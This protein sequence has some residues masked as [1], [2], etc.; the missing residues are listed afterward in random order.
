MIL[1]VLLLFFIVIILFTAYKLI[2]NKENEKRE[3]E[4]SE[5]LEVSGNNVFKS[6]KDFTIEYKASKIPRNIEENNQYISV[7]YITENGNYIRMGNSEV[8]KKKNEVS[9]ET[10]IPGN[11]VVLCRKKPYGITVE[12]KIKSGEEPLLLIHGPLSGSQTWNKLKKEIRREYP[13]RA[14]LIFDY[15][16]NS[17][18]SSVARLLSDELEKLHDKYGDFRSD[19]ITHS[20]GSQVLVG[21]IARNSYQDDINSILYLSPTLNGVTCV[22][23]DERDDF[24]DEL[25]HTKGNPDLAATIMASWLAGGDEAEYLIPRNEHYEELYEKYRD[26]TRSVQAGGK[27][28]YNIQIE[29]LWGNKTPDIYQ[30]PYNRISILS[31]EPY[32][33]DNLN[34]TKDSLV[35]EKIIEFYTLPDPYSTAYITDKNMEDLYKESIYN[36]SLHKWRDTNT[37]YLYQMNRNMLSTVEENGILFTNGDLDTYYAWDL[38]NRENYRADVAVVNLSLLNTPWFIKL[39][40]DEMGVIF[41]LPDSQIDSAQDVVSSPLY[42]LRLNSN[43]KIIIPGNNKHEGFNVEY[44]RN[45]ILSTSDLAVIKIIKDNYGNRPIYFPATCGSVSGF[46]DHL[47]NEG[48]ADKVVSSSG[49]SQFNLDKLIN[50][51]NNVYEFDGIEENYDKVDSNTRRLFNNYGATFL[52][53]SIEYKIKGE[54]DQAVNYFERGL[55]FI[56]DKERFYPNLINLATE[57]AKDVLEKNND[58]QEKVQQAIT[59]LEE[60]KLMELSFEDTEEIDNMINELKNLEK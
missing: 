36:I 28:E 21:Y 34:I 56:E 46:G 8:D 20:S 5:I 15:A 54:Y 48:M 45:D 58:D 42:P 6:E 44:N 4:I 29:A 12:G 1:K 7:Y 11:Y 47:M 2:N 43:K 30:P 41:N 51:L 22:L 25:K 53:A 23:E 26:K 37:F 40:K 33:I 49:S 32:N 38:Q 27:A 52:R 60:I 24:L 14:L 9:F 18:L 31:R 17:P 50:N 55:V 13:K 16:Q 10:I 57:M 59:K 3:I 19:V 35:I 39:V